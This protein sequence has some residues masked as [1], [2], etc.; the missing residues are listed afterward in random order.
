[1][2]KSMFSGPCY[3]DFKEREDKLVLADW[4]NE[5]GSVVLGGLAVPRGLDGQCQSG[6]RAS[7]ETAEARTV[8]W[9]QGCREDPGR[10]EA[11]AGQLAQG[12]AELL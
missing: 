7:N 8:R 4:K 5:R 12:S 1:M 6:G 10:P 2:L 3:T 9:A 11:A